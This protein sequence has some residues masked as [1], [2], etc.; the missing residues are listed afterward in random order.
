M[1]RLVSI[2]ESPTFRDATA[3]RV[4]NDLLRARFGDFSFDDAV[5]E[6]LGRATNTDI[7]GWRNSIRN[8]LRVWAITPQAG[9]VIPFE[10][11]GHIGGK[12]VVLEISAP[13]E[14]ALLLQV[15]S[16]LRVVG[17]ERVRPCDCRRLFVRTGKRQ[18]CSRRCQKRV[19]MRRFR[20]GEA[21]KE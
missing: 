19:Y 11:F 21:G 7:Q 10:A 3:R 12:D 17:R 20:A 16:A 6:K 9:I 8:A 2:A 18:Y 14:Q 13:V 4:L 5:S 15:A 1:V